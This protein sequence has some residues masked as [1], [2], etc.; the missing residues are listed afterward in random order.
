MM[1]VKMIKK[2]V[3]NQNALNLV[4]F[5]KRKMFVTKINIV[6]LTMEYATNFVKILE[7]VQ[8]AILATIPSVLKAVLVLMIV[9]RI[10]IVMSND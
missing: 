5:Q 10:N 8:M 4:M 1:I 9:A 6:I 3:G 2:Y 7:N